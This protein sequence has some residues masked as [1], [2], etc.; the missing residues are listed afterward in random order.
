[1]TAPMIDRSEFISF[2]KSIN[3]VSPEIQ[4]SMRKRLNVAAK[5]IVAD[6]KQAALSLP[7]KVESG[8][9]QQSYENLFSLRRAVASSVKSRFNGT[10][11]G[12]VLQIRVSTT[13]FMAISG[14]PRTL[15][16]YL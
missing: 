12:G 10:G 16:Y 6:I 4:K 7:S 1:M 3:A 9:T 5:P 11:K 8:Q 13:D 14:R 15:P 2:Y